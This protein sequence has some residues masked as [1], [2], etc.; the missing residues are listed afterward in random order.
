MIENALG[1]HQVLI[2]DWYAIMLKLSSPLSPAVS[3]WE[4]MPQ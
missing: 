3:L 4:T 1:G 2:R